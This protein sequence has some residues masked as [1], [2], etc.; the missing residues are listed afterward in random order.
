[1]EKNQRIQELVTLLNEASNAYY[2]EDR[3]IMSNYEY[4]ALYDEL[5]AL[6]KET[7]IILPNSPS[8]NAGYEVVSKLTKVEHKHP[9][10]SLDKTKDR[11]SLKGWL[12]G[13]NG[14][15]S[16]KM[17]GLTIVAT[18]N[19]GKLISAVTRGNGYVGEDVTHNAKYFAGL[20]QK[21][22]YQGELI[23]RGEAVMT[24]SEFER[25]N[26]EMPASMPK[27]KNPRNL[28]SATVRLFDSEES[29]KRKIIFFAFDLVR[30]S[31]R[32]NTIDFNL[33]SNQC[34]WLEEQG[35]TVVERV[36]VT[37]ETIVEAIESYQEALQSNDF[38][39]DGLVLIFDDEAYGVSLGM[40]GKFPR[41]GIAF[42][43]QDETVESIIRQ[44]EWSASRTGLLNPVAIFDPVEIEGT[45]VSRASIHN[46]SIAKS[47]KL[48][49]GS[50]IA[51][52]KAN[53]IIPQIYHTIQSV[54]ETEIPDT[55]P[56]C[57]GK[58]TIKLNDD[59]ETLYCV[60]EECPA[61][62]IGKFTHFVERDCMNIVGFSEATIE[63][64]ISSGFIHELADIYKISDFKN[65]IVK[66]D[67]FGEKS[68][69]NLIDAIENSRTVKF[70]AF[71]NA[72]GIAGIGKDM[73][74][75][76]SKFLGENALEA[77]LQMLKN[78][79]RF[80]QIDGI[81]A[82][83]N[84]NIYRWY[85]NNIINK[86]FN[87]LISVLVI[88]DDAI[89]VSES[90]ITGRTFVITGSVTQFR[91]RDELKAY[92]ESLGGKTSGSVSAKTDFLIN[93][94]VSSNSGKNK[95]AKELGVPI[96]SEDDFIKM[97]K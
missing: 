96:I 2:N 79:E 36:I 47:L 9:A 90:N 54:G 87:N 53:L 18:Y 16:W 10:L 51:V 86:E 32:P 49:I 97:T 88:E 57:G 58:T 20:P 73:A 44:I 68:Y 6:E 30:I 12:K 89:K 3:E 11:E 5:L 94:D 22:T 15:L 83:I 7:G 63:K 1:M 62:Q 50:R 69:N 80:D 40:T 26:S 45:T 52:Y 82:I 55:C 33:K 92:I 78:G 31:D 39:S 34:N 27:Y 42:K 38:P 66:M 19:K 70:S 60:N 95:K 8:Q 14:L 37:P 46:V 29:S 35:F 25:I 77:F 85:N 48:G 81:G 28:A 41:S 75:Q 71:L 76:I 61:K 24:Y 84:D 56:V 65:T 23:V 59:I 43:W 67:G 64:F 74:K 93:N 17:D 72:V 91:N 13:K 4:D 21:I